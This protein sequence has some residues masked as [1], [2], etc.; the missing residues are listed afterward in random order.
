[1]KS[2][3]IVYIAYENVWEKP[4]NNQILVAYH[5]GILDD[6]LNGFIDLWTKL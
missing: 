6:A 5:S 2:V 1:M 3:T 4:N